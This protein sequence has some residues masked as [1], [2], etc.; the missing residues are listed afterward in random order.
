[1]KQKNK[2]QNVTKLKISNCDETQKLIILTKT[3]KCYCK[4]FK[5]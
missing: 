1:M 5:N 2:A 3:L 4:K